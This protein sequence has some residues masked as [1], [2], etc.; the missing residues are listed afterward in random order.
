MSAISIRKAVRDE[1]EIVV[2]LVE[3]LLI[4]LGEK[5]PIAKKSTISLCKRFFDEGKY[6]AFIASDL[7]GLPIGI[8]TLMETTSLYAGGKIGIIQELYIMPEFRSQAVGLQLLNEA[9]KY[10]KENGWARLEV[11][12]P[13]QESSARTISFYRREGFKGTSLKLK[14]KLQ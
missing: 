5:L 8:I 13:N 6:A 11:A 10:G 1:A 2:D 9:E 7:T 4:E 3:S 12:T 14:K